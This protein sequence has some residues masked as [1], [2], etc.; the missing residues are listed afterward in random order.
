MYDRYSTIFNSIQKGKNNTERNSNCKIFKRW[1]SRG[2]ETKSLHCLKLNYIIHKKELINIFN[3]E[4]SKK[5]N[6]K[7]T[8]RYI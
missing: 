1:E 3:L 2:M 7:T 4:I 8:R 5:N 6:K